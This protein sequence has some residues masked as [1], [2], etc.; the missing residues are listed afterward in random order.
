MFIVTN[1]TPTGN[2]TP[3]VFKEMKDAIDWIYECTANNIKACTDKDLSNMTNIEVC[4]AAE[5]FMDCKISLYRTE[6]YYSD[7]TY[8]IMELFEVGDIY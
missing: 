1:C 2:Y 6:L 7:D 5:Y 3:N 4:H 8:N